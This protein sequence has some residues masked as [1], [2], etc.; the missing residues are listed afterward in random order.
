[1]IRRAKINDAEVLAGLAIRMWEDH[2]L[3]ELTD[4]F[5]EI[6]T[7]GDAVCFIKYIDEKPIAFAQCQL[8]Y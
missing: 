5:K 6:V 3:A 4:E 2:T 8:R 7:K 1:M